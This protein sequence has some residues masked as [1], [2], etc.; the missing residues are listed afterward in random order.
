M[1]GPL[2]AEGSGLHRVPTI[3]VGVWLLC[4]LLTSVPSRQALPQGAL[5]GSRQGPVVIPALSRRPAG[6]LPWR[7][8]PP[9]GSMAI[10]ALSDRPSVRL[11]RGHEPLVRQISPDKNMNFP[12]TTAAFTLPLAS[13]GLRHLVPTRPGAEPS[14][15]FPSV[16]SHL[17][18]RAS[19]GHPL[20]GL[21]LP[22]AVCRSL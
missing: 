13:D 11:P 16:G 19:S 14:M 12:C 22:L 1:H 8:Q 10:P 20:A 3:T 21:P 5:P 4:R 15:G 2:F 6:R 18:A 7:P 9:W 17:C